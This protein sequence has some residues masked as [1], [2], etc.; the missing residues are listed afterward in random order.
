MKKGLDLQGGTRVVL[1]PAEQLSPEDMESL[2]SSMSQLERVYSS[3]ITVRSS[4]SSREL[5]WFWEA[6]LNC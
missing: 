2:T 4:R 5:G 1:Q 6:I 3:D